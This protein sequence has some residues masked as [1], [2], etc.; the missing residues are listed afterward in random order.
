MKIN[1][2]S[3]APNDGMSTQRW[4]RSQFN[5][6]YSNNDINASQ[7]MLVPATGEWGYSMTFELSLGK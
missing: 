1:L 3:K 4:K 7:I 2:F 6:M 5:T